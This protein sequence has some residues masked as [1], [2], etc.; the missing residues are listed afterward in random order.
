MVEVT[1]AKSVARPLTRLFHSLLPFSRSIYVV[2]E[3]Q[4]E[5]G[6]IAAGGSGV[7]GFH[8]QRENWMIQLNIHCLFP[9]FPYSIVAGGGCTWHFDAAIV[10]V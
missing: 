2:T 6:S 4:A 8:I 3:S 10:P 1:V 7:A 5:M 9:Q